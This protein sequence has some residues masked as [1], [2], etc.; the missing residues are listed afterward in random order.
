MVFSRKRYVFL[1]SVL[2]SIC[3]VMHYKKHEKEEDN[4]K[5]IVTILTVATLAAAVLTGCGSKQSAPAA[6]EAVQT[7]AAA[8]SKEETAAAHGYPGSGDQ[9]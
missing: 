7:T 9:L 3:S 4:M 8:E 2:R 1:F 6:T 5:K